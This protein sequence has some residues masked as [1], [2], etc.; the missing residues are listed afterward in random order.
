MGYCSFSGRSVDEGDAFCVNCAR[1]LFLDLNNRAAP[2]GFHALC[3]RCHG[4]GLTDSLDGKGKI[5]CDYPGCK[6]GRITSSAAPA[7]VS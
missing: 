3:P 1:K 6:D 5:Y 7:P 4:S 2:S